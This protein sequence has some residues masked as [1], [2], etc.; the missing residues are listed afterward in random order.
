MFCCYDV[1]L[2]A[3]QGEGFQSNHGWVG[4]MSNVKSITIIL[5]YMN[6]CIYQRRQAALITPK[7]ARRVRG[8][9]FCKNIQLWG[10]QGLCCGSIG[11]QA[12]NYV[13]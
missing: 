7:P 12:G 8:G 11:I 2:F 3:W 5:M 4:Q 13:Q 9:D 6:Y 1:S 10:Q